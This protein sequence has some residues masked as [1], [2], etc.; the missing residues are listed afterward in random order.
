MHVDE[1][2]R[3]GRQAYCFFI[4]GRWRKIF[5]FSYHFAQVD[6][7]QRDF[8]FT[9]LIVSRKSIKIVHGKHQRLSPYFTVGKILDERQ[10]IFL[11]HIR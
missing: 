11:G 6:G 5:Q 8:H 1:H 3:V 4:T 10:V 7:I 9:N 2:K